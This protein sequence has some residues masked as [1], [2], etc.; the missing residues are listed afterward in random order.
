[1][2]AA[3]VKVQAA[4]ER[5]KGSMRMRGLLGDSAS[6]TEVELANEALREDRRALRDAEDELRQAQM[7]ARGADLTAAR[8]RRLRRRAGSR[9]PTLALTRDGLRRGPARRAVA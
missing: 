1:M 2:I 3:E 5:L 7:T 4:K 8:R 9:A 6:A